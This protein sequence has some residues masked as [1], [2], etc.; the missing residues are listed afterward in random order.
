MGLHHT[1]RGGC[2]VT[3]DGVWDTPA[4]AEENFDCIP[5]DSC[6]DRPGLDPIHNFMDYSDDFC[7]NHFTKGQFDR[8]QRQWSLYRSNN[9][10]D[11][12]FNGINGLLGQ[13]IRMLRGAFEKG[14]DV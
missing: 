1:F 3:G 11:F 6:P 5:R 13:E 14:D 2:G 9:P 10:F 4:E 7:M 12:N 8:M